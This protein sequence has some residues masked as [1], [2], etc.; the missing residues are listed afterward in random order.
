MS[1][2]PKPALILGLGGVIPFAATSLA[3]LAG[4]PE[5]MGVGWDFYLLIYGLM[6]LAFMAGCM[7]A[8]A[9]RDDDPQGYGLSTLPALFGA[10]VIAIGIPLALVTER[11]ALVILALTFAALLLL[12]R[13]AARHDQTPPWWM[14]LR[15]LLTSLVGLSLIIGAFT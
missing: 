13:R 9:A 15:L 7:W 11:E 10:F 2:I 5:P 8:F 3:P 12:D 1:Q 6:I 4:L 14:R